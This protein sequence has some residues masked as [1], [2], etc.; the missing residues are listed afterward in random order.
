MSSHLEVLV[1]DDDRDL[2]ETIQ[3]ILTGWGHHVTVAHDG[4]RAIAL[5]RDREF[6]LC[7]M[8]VRLP[9]QNGVES[10]LEIRR[11][12][13]EAKVVIMTGYSIEDLLARAVGSGAL[14][15]LHKPLEVAEILRAVERVGGRG[16]VL[17]VDD[18]GDFAES[19]KE[20]LLGAGYSALLA[21]DGGT[22]LAKLRD[23][24]VDVMVLDL[25][26]PV[27]SG[28]EVCQE[29]ARAGRAVPTIVVTGY[30][31]EE[32]AAIEALKS[33]VSDV[34]VKPV[35]LRALL[36]AVDQARGQPPA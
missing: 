12:R 31:R 23:G 19:L 22:A 21:H 36:Q 33:N 18:D 16:V 6:D 27:R 15:V 7:F 3:D 34:L 14:E 32:A 1:V 11:L 24:T 20:T 26:L 2:A 17:V 13:P 25:R 9:G 29:L 8:D 35:D 10:F 30:P 5:F 4:E 28:L